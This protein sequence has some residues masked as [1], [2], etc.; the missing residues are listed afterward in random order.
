MDA[1]TPLLLALSAL[2]ALGAG[3]GVAFWYCLRRARRQDR[4][5]QSAE[6]VSTLAHHQH[7]IDALRHQLRAA[8]TRLRE[9][10]DAV[11]AGVAIYDNQDRLV[12]F[13]REVARLTPYRGEGTVLGETYETLM[14]RALEAGQIPD[15]IG[16][17][18]EWLA[19]RLAGRGAL[20]RH[21]DHG[22]W[23]HLQETRTASGYLV[24]TRLDLAPL[25]EK[26]LA[27]ERAHEQQLR[28]S[29]TDGLI[30]IANRRQFELSL[31]TEWQRC[32]RT[33]SSLSLLMV[34]ID[35]FKHYN[36]HYGHLGGDEC[37]RQV[38]R[39]LGLCVKRSGE[40]VA[41]YDGEEFALLLP[42]TDSAEARR[43]AQRCLHAMLDAR[44]P[45]EGSP[46]SPWLTVSIGMA[47]LVATPGQASASLVNDAL[48]ALGHAKQ[49]GRARVEGLDVSPVSGPASL[50]AAL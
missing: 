43:V 17:E 15:A 35:H 20:Q 49:G 38:A 27:L 36:D 7:E 8:E 16:R 48:T 4:S 21:I 50:P 1:P 39:I 12:G 26:G 32:A 29:T 11:P 23:I 45:H 14:R 28:L 37:L 25:I 31:Q 30:G 33:Q 41:R 18:E 42:G 40:L 2:L 6:F 13:N 24:M 10:I 5:A 34:D 19:L 9:V 46:V 47:T 3:L 22:P 44:I